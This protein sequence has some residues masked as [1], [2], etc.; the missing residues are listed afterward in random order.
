MAKKTKKAFYDK[1][2]FTNETEYFIFLIWGVFVCA[3]LIQ[4]I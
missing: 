1:I 4:L 2:L 3:F